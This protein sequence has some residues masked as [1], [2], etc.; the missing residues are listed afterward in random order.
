VVADDGNVPRIVVAVR[1]VLDCRRQS[2]LKM[3]ATLRSAKAVEYGWADQ[4]PI[5]PPP[6]NQPT[7]EPT[8]QPT[9]HK[10][11]KRTKEPTNEPTNERTTN[12]QPTNQPTNQSTN[13]HSIVD[14]MG[15]FLGIDRSRAAVAVAVAVVLPVSCSR[16]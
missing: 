9:N 14:E 6:M 2:A 10:T 4:L 8:N 1:L 7:N 3:T 15:V 12:D 11:N 16:L 5:Q 13:Q